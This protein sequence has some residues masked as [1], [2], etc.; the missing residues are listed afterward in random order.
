MRNYG[1]FIANPDIQYQE[2]LPFKMVADLHVYKI[3]IQDNGKIIPLMGDY[4][5]FHE[6]AEGKSYTIHPENRDKYIEFE[7]YSQ[8]SDSGSVKDEPFLWIIHGWIYCTT[9]SSKV[10]DYDGISR[11][12]LKANDE[13]HT[14]IN[15]PG[16]PLFL[17]HG[18]IPE[19]TLIY[20][21]SK[22][23]I[24]T[25]CILIDKIEEIYPGFFEL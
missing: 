17:M 12:T 22:K 14:T 15:V 1:C 16:S 23:E 20:Y 9:R 8:S 24:L 11:H 5:P 21:N 7:Q 10:W 3:G 18:R 4:E 6:Y 25:S 19:G 13:S 2:D